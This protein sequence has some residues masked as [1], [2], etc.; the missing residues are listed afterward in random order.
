LKKLREGKLK[1]K[2]ERA[3]KVEEGMYM[4]IYQGI[5]GWKAVFPVIFFFL[6]DRLINTKQTLVFNSW[7]SVS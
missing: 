2:K 5:G 3:V 4:K 1:K 6:L 7:A